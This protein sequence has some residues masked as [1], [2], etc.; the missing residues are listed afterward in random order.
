[1]KCYVAYLLLFIMA[2]GL[3][4]AVLTAP[5]NIDW[6]YW[7]QPKVI[8]WSIVWGVISAGLLWGLYRLTAVWSQERSLENQ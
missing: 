8:E 1:M 7:L 4:T 6:A 3:P 5:W 2:V